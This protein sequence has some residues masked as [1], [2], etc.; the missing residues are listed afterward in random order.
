MDKLAKRISTDTKANVKPY[1]GRSTSH[2]KKMTE[3]DN[4]ANGRNVYWRR[5][6]GKLVQRSENKDYDEQ[7]KTCAY[8]IECTF[9]VTVE[10]HPWSE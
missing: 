1:S 7:M 3:E 10:E 9:G 2:H 4:S 6:S 5:S 8:T